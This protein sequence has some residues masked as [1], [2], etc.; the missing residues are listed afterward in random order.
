M[1]KI[2]L[3]RRRLLGIGAASASSLILAG[4][5]QFDFLGR[6]DDPTRDFLEKANDLTYRVQRAVVGDTVLAREYS[7]TEIRQGQKPNGSVDP[8]QSNPEYVALR[9]GGFAGYRL[10]VTGLVEQEKSYSLAELMNMP[11]R[12]QITRHDCVEGWSCIAK[13]SGT[14]LGPVLDASRL[15]PAAKY[16]V[17][18][19]YDSMGGGLSG[20]E[21]YY[22]SCDI[23]DAHHPQTILAYGLNNQALPVANGAPVRVRVERALGYKQPKYVHTIEAVESFTQIGR[24]KGGYWEDNGYDWYGGI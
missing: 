21:A 6:R 23:V 4:C 20:P 12:T 17:F 24:G 1:K 3:N 10:T 5:D 7:E 18:H 13:W 9:D 11:N 15:K 8:S 19:C 22:T 16:I 14:P 2:V